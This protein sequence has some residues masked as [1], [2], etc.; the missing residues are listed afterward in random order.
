M[1]EGKVEKNDAYYNDIYAQMILSHL[2]TRARNILKRHYPTYHLLLEL[3]NNPSNIDGIKSCGRKTKEEILCFLSVLKEN[4]SN[5]PTVEI[6]SK[7]AFNLIQEQYPFLSK[8]DILFV[9]SFKERE[10]RLPLL[11]IIIRYFETTDNRDFRI[12]SNTW[13]IANHFQKPD[14]ITLS[15]ERIRQITQKVDDNIQN[16]ISTII[17]E[18]EWDEYGLDLFFSISDNRLNVIFEKERINNKYLGFYLLSI[19]TKSDLFIFSREG[20]QLGINTVREKSKYQLYLDK[21]DENA[22]PLFKKKLGPL[23]FACSKKFSDFKIRLYIYMVFSAV[24][25]EYDFDIYSPLKNCIYSD[26][27]W[28]S[29]ISKEQIIYYQYERTE[30]YRAINTIATEIAGA[31]CVVKGAL[32]TKAKLCNYARFVYESLMEE[33]SKLNT[34]ELYIRFLQRFPDNTISKESFSSKIRD[35]A[36]VSE[37]IKNYWTVDYLTEG[38]PSIGNE[39]CPKETLLFEIVRMQSSKGLFYNL[40]ALRTWND[41]VVNFISNYVSHCCGTLRAF[42]NHFQ[43]YYPNCSDNDVLYYLLVYSQRLGINVDIELTSKKKWDDL[44]FDGEVYCFF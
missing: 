5:V 42:A 28:E 33:G 39:Y 10:K 2:S 3:D 1:I 23:L 25:R 4:L 26:A 36:N 15:K 32:S 41:S 14:A 44:W 11:Y 38:Y 16:V 18:E 22:P 7:T 29:N 6:E 34:T 37:I 31:K 40:Y 19:G 27:Y 43:D 24:K 13:G 17:N 12:W 35:I 20:K 30:L 8:D 9:R 21:I